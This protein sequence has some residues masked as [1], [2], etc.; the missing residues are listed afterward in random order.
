LKFEYKSAY[1]NAARYLIHS[2]QKREENKNNNFSGEISQSVRD[3]VL[4][5]HHEQYWVIKYITYMEHLDIRLLLQ[6][7]FS[8]QDAHVSENISRHAIPQKT[9][10]MRESSILILT[11]SYAYHIL[12][13]SIYAYLKFPV[14]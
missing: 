7:V 10:V 11:I 13:D 14:P 1:A 8:R 3:R 4:E 9:L 12:F 5:L 2:Y 6:G